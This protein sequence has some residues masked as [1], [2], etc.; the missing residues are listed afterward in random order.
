[1]ESAHADVL[2]GLQAGFHEEVST[3]TSQ[4]VALEEENKQLCML[5][6]AERKAHR[7][8]IDV[9]NFRKLQRWQ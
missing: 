7:S 8:A 6:E 3:L 9:L 4:K 5:L 1:M 2:S